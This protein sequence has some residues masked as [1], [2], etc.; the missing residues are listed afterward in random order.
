MPSSDNRSRPRKSRSQPHEPRQL[1]EIK[2][3]SAQAAASNILAAQQAH[4]A[5]SLNLRRP[6]AAPPAIA[7]ESLAPAAHDLLLPQSPLPGHFPGANSAS[8]AGITMSSWLAL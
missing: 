5:A 3:C 7:R 6:L 4:P 2:R 1:V 8:S